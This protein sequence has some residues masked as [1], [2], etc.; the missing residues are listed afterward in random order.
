[1][2]YKIEHNK[3]AERFEAHVDGMTAVVD[4]KKQNGYYAVTHTGVPKPISGQ[5]IAA[6]LTKA[7]LDYIRKEGAK[8]L[9]LCPY[10]EAYIERHPEYWDLLVE[11]AN[12]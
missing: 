5:G 10:T 11:R 7:L 6:A 1:M 9:P 3:E 2:E 4:Y 8:V 12:Y